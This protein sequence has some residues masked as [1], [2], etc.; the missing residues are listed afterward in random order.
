MIDVCAEQGLVPPKFEE[1]DNFF[2]VTLFNS[3]IRPQKLQEWEK[4]LMDYVDEYGELSAKQAKELLKV[5]PKTAGTRLRK[6]CDKG[7]LA[8]VSSGPYDPHKKF[9]KPGN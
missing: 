4:K 5:T 1:V 7:L 2:R 3:L 6:M 8:E 9:V